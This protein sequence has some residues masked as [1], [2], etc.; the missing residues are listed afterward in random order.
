MWDYQRFWGFAIS[1]WC[2]G[3]GYI[4]T[5][6]PESQDIPIFHLD[7][8]LFGNSL[9]HFIFFSN[10]SN[11]RFPQFCYFCRTYRSYHIAV[12]IYYILYLIII[13]PSYMCLQNPSQPVECADILHIFTV[14]FIK[15]MLAKVK[16]IWL[17]C[18][19]YFS[20]AIKIVWNNFDC[21]VCAVTCWCHQKNR[22]VLL[23]IMSLEEQGERV[24]AA[25]GLNINELAQEKVK[26]NNYSDRQ[27]KVATIKISS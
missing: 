18:V 12:W 23:L 9:R 20:K 13:S 27:R 2:R 14:L 24:I 16:S 6:P 21:T 17:Q 22:I 5:F 11:I 4:V 8:T 19:I 3:W 15:H 7:C 26:S 25:I 1:Q 10:S